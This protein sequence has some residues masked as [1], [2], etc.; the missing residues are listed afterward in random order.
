MSRQERAERWPRAGWLRRARRQACAE[1]RALVRG[2]LRVTEDSMVWAAAA[3]W[4]VMS[5]EGWGPESR[6]KLRGV[7]WPRQA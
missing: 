7:L 6:G 2:P 4:A 5:P 1:G 3:A